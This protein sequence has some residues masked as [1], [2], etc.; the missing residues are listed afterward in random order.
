MLNPSVEAC[1]SVMLLKNGHLSVGKNSIQSF[2]T[3]SFDSLYS[4]VAALYADFISVKNQVD[5]LQENCDFSRMIISMFDEEKTPGVKLNSLLKQRNLIFNRIFRGT[6]RITE[7]GNGLS[8]IDCSANINYMIPRALPIDLYS[9]V[10]KRKCD[11]CNTEVASNRCFID[12]NIEKLEQQS[13]HNL[14]SCLLDTFLSEKSSNCECGG[15][16]KLTETEFSNFIMIDLYLTTHI[17]QISLVEIPKKLDIFGI[18]FAIFG[19]IEYIGDD[20]NTNML[21]ASIGHY[22]SHIYRRNNRWQRYDDTKSKITNSNTTLKIK[23]QVLFY[24]K[25]NVD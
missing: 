21:N 24:V 1:K 6:T 13:I 8:S 17:A 14:N 11:R 25:K 23:G 22:V 12:I 9:Y 19:C 4:M 16:K 3:C 2:N 10:R 7:F 20:E 5:L 15:S 18:E